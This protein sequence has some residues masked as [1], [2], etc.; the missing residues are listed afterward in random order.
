MEAARISSYKP[1]Q[2]FPTL[3]S[4]S[5]CKT[6]QKLKIDLNFS[7]KPVSPQTTPTA[8]IHPP[9]LT[10][11][12]SIFTK[13]Q[14][15]HIG[16]SLGS[17]SKQNPHSFCKMVSFEGNEIIKYPSHAIEV[18]R[19]IPNLPEWAKK[20]VIQCEVVHY[21][22]KLAKTDCNYSDEKGEYRILLGDDIQY[23]YEIIEKLGKGTFGQVAKVFDHK[24]K[25]NL[26]IKIIKNRQ[27][28]A[29]QARMEIEIL[30]YLKNL[31]PLKVHSTV[32]IHESFIFRGHTVIPT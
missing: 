26:A 30:N 1:N 11:K 18:L 25:Q 9:N 28:Y 22:S 19:L 23:R 15:I 32:Q 4:S 31:D 27:R 3:L 20:E 10:P 14:L 8:K 24:N 29:D 16:K 2:H 7:S 21:L 17:S 12:S 6:K 5:M 13:A